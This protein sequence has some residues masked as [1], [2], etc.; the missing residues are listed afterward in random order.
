MIEIKNNFSLNQKVSSQLAFVLILILSFVVAWFTIDTG[1]KIVSNAKTSIVF[2][3]EKRVKN[4][5]PVTKPSEVN[6]N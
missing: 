1:Q 5:I 2:N 4:E 6:K 3:A